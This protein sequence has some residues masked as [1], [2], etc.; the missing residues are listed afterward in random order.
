[1]IRILHPMLSIAGAIVIINSYNLSFEVHL[2]S[3][4]VMNIVLIKKV[5]G[6]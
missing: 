1:M 3:V 4:V 2:L 6:R 5:M